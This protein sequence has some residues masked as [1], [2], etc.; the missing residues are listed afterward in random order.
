M[1]VCDKVCD[2]VVDDVV[3]KDIVGVGDGVEV[4]EIVGV[5]VIER[6]EV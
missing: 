6:D 5:C 1:T 2:S 4:V 3:V